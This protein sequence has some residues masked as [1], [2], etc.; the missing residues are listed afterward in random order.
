[1]ACGT[2]RWIARSS[3]PREVAMLGVVAATGRDNPRPAIRSLVSRPTGIIPRIFRILK[4][5]QK[6]VPPRA[7]E[8]P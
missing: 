7:N 1:M 2:S 6:A 8:G 3:P 4:T 5:G